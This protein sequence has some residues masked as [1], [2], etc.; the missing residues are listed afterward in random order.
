MPP[1]TTCYRIG[2]RDYIVLYAQ[3]GESGETV[4]KFDSEPTVDVSEAPTTTSSYT[5]GLL[6]LNYALD[7]DQYIG[8]QGNSSITIVILD[9]DS[10]YK[11]HAPILPGEGDFPNYFSIGSNAS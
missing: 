2:D 11:W 8:V 1:L 7:G 9:K 3:P 5:D 4:L 6:A 10:A